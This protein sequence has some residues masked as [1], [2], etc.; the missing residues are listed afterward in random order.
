M[1]FESGR[2]FAFSVCLG[3]IEFFFSLIDKQEFCSVTPVCLTYREPQ[4]HVLPAGG[5]YRDGG[6][7]RG[8]G[9]DERLR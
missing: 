4:T 2:L 8:S 9:G 3:G 7:V 5:F 1:L 6:E